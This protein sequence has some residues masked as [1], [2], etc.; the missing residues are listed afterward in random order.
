[1]T[2]LVNRN[3]CI[4]ASLSPNFN[5]IGTKNLALLASLPV[6]HIELLVG[7]HLRNPFRTGW[8]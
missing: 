3:I 7:P 6:R 4:M 2:M 1:M 8:C 5:A